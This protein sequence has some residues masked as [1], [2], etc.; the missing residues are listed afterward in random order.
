MMTSNFY[1]R[2][3]IDPES[4]AS[5]ACVSAHKCFRTHPNAPVVVCLRQRATLHILLLLF[6]CICSVLQDLF[7][8]YPSFFSLSSESFPS[9]FLSIMPLSV[10][11]SSASCLL[12]FNAL[13]LSYLSWI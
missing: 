11:I 2:H 7:N 8:I 9:F 4:M 12:S 6:S 1:K 13:I 3:E 5:A 10:Q